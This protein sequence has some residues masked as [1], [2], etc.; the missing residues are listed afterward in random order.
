MSEQTEI[1][2]HTRRLVK[3][4]MNLN[5]DIKGQCRIRIMNTCSTSFYGDKPMYQ[6][7]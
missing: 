2:E 6:I 4:S 7:W 5:L 3:N 1:I